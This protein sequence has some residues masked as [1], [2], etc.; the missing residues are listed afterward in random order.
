MCHEI[1]SRAD[2]AEVV[3]TYPDLLIFRTLSLTFAQDQMHSEHNSRLSKTNTDVSSIFHK[4][5]TKERV[6]ALMLGRSR[7]RA[8]TEGCFSLFFLSPES[9]LRTVYSGSAK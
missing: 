6:V 5:T 8:T 3:S 7:N 1:L 4:W 2:M 9:E